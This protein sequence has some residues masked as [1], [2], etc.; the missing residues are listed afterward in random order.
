MKQASKRGAEPAASS[1]KP[2]AAARTAHRARDQSRVPRGHH[3][4]AQPSSNPAAGSSGSA[5]ARARPSFTAATGPPRPTIETRPTSPRLTTDGKLPGGSKG[6]GRLCLSLAGLRGAPAKP[7]SPG[8]P[9]YGRALL[10]CRVADW[11]GDVEVRDHAVDE[12]TAAWR[13]SAAKLG[14]DRA[15][16][17]VLSS[18]E[19]VRRSAWRRGPCRCDRFLALASCAESQELRVKE[20]QPRFAIAHAGQKALQ[21]RWPPKAVREWL[22]HRPVVRVARGSSQ[23]RSSTPRLWQLCNGLA[24]VVP[25]SSPNARKR[26]QAQAA[27]LGGKGRAAPMP[28]FFRPLLQH[29]ERVDEL[30]A[31][32]RLRPDALLPIE[33]HELERVQVGQIHRWIDAIQHVAEVRWPGLAARS[34]VKSSDARPAD[35]CVTRRRSGGCR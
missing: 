34:S 22:E 17:P 14:R 8:E 7:E 29:L 23:R 28:W 18:V 15:N 6:Q 24:M 10:P 27:R 25:S 31:A 12:V 33:R 16:R 30:R 1:T 2:G 21:Q 11:A 3:R 4:E 19:L 20:P 32:S 13:Y 5:A 9:G 35:T 26:S